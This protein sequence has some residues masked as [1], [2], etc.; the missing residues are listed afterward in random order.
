MPVIA[1][2][3]ITPCAT[4][5]DDGV[6]VAPPASVQLARTIDPQTGELQLLLTGLHPVDAAVARAFQL[7]SGTGAALGGKGTRFGEIGKA[8]ATAKRAIELEAKRVATPLVTA[9]MIRLRSVTAT[10][11]GDTA[12]LLV[13]YMNLYTGRDEQV[14][15]TI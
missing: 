11:T 5:L 6:S 12:E 3:G 10:V 4:P 14:R 9:G 15:R 13:E 8:G 7:R 1:P 2:A